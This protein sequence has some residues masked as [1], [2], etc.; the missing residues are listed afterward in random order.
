MGLFDENLWSQNASLE[1]LSSS[2]KE[3]QIWIGTKE[4]AKEKR[5]D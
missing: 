4:R 1:I 5:R 3:Q 2:M